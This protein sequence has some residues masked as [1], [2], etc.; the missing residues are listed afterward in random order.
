MN[1]NATARPISGSFQFCIRQ[2]G[3]GGRRGFALVVTLSLMV[4]LA[5]VAVAMLSLASIELRKS[6]VGEARA[7]A[8]ANARLGLMLAMGQLQSDLGDDRRAT[9]DA[10]I[11]A[12]SKNPAAVG[13]WNGWSP[14]MATKSG[15]DRVVRVNYQAPKSQ[16]GFRSWLVSNPD[17]LATRQLAWH[18]AEPAAGANAAVLFAEKTSGFELAGGKVPVSSGGKPGTVAWAVSQENTKARINIG[19]DDTK[20][21]SAEDNMQTPSRPHLANSTILKHP[22]AGWTQRATKV[23][24]LA[25]AVLDPAYGASRELIGKAAKDF[26]VESFTLLTD[27][28]K[29]GLKADLT[30]GFDMPEEDFAKD[31]WE[32]AWGTVKN[33]FRSPVPREYKGQKPLFQ[34]MVNN[35]QAQVFMNFEPA[36]VNHK[37]QANAVPTFE[38]LRSYARTYRHLYNVTGKGTT[39]FERPFSHI[40]TPEMVPGRPF[41]TRSQPALAPVLDR[42]NMFF[43]I[44]AKSTGELCIL[45][46]PIVTIWNPHNVDIE[47]EGLVVY[48]WIDLAVF[49]NWNVSR[50]DG[51]PN[52][53]WNSSLSRF[54]GEGYQG[55]GRSSRPYFYLHLTQ[56]GSIV[57][58]GTQTISPP[59]RLEPGE[60]RV[61]C[62]ADNSRRDLEILGSAPVRTWRMKAVNSASDI[63]NSLRGGITLNMTKSI[64]GGNNFNYRLKNGDTVNAH[65]A[66]FDRNTYYYIVNMADSYHIKNP[67]V[68]LMVDRRPANGAFGELPAEKNLYFYGQIH[69]GKAFG[70][71]RDVMNYPSY[72]Y[73]LINETPRLVGSILTYH[74]VAESSGQPLSDLMFTTNPRQAFVNPYLSAAQFQ[75]GPHYESLMMEGASLAGLTMETTG[76]GKKAFYGASHSSARGRT[77]LA[78]F[79]IPRS[80]TLS[81]G[82]F[83]HCDIASTAFS[84]ASQIANSWASPY[85]PSNS[86]SRRVTTGPDGETIGPSGLGVFDIS[87]LA[88]EALFD[89]CYLSGAAP[90][91]GTR[92]TTTG[93][94]AVWE[95]DQIS[96]D[97]ETSEFLARFFTNPDFTPLRNPRM[98]PYRGS[99]TTEELKQRMDSPARCVRLAA[100]LMVN[101][102]FNI[103]STSEEAWM[104][105]LSSLRGAK[106]A[107]TDKT[108]FSRFRHILSSAPVNMAENDPWSGFRT[109]SDRELKSLAQNLIAEV[110]ARGPFLSLGEFVNR[111]VST[112]VGPDRSPLYLAGAIQSAIDKS[113]LNKI[114]GYSSFN[115]TPY[116]YPANIPTP[117][118]GTNTPGW[119][120]QAD[121]LHGL[122]PFIVSRSDT[123]IIRSLGEAKDS[124]G[125]VLASARLEA[126]VQRVPD[127]VDP[128]DDAATPVA[129]L[130]SQANKSFGRRFQIV[131][132]R[133]IQLDPSGNP[134]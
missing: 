112:D 49:W 56:N 30:T 54:V 35:P 108:A 52:Q 66:E 74:R 68:E 37:F 1:T 80:P 11:L 99:L 67:N 86:V 75:T 12:D 93:S 107:S 61:F 91:F 2:P 25:Q 48:P 50:A 43:S 33:P 103:N 132:I 15:S 24:T 45:L 57:R 3:D 111:R 44:Y 16:T 101:G 62:L 64:G 128:T 134:I 106:P 87:Y 94:P 14:D 32:D 47:T 70:K 22:P 40:A 82:S 130:K 109:V 98:T 114:Y 127:W 29:G 46:T 53:T 8:M 78:F 34:P 39:A 123:F 95:T 81:L 21:I 27:P 4:L 17:P 129:E 85:V 118:T 10:S 13:V 9:A 36:S 71:S 76:D 5:V 104:A 88:N 121:V 89:S 117:N 105:V 7:I 79:E 120:T 90:R 77:N 96:E 110:K 131:S 126:V 119:L 69:S 26:T 6:S 59:I 60:V 38:T 65:K 125:R 133:E 102:G 83:Q 63:T 113:D 97:L 20:R 19:T 84:P 122:A 55:H 31:S 18:A 72:R 42:M 28:V 51:G 23:C 100:H 73:E 115:K 58:P 92:R 116:P 41:G 124:G